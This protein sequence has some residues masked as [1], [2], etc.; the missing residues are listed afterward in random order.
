MIKISIQVL[1]WQIMGGRA[2]FFVFATCFTKS[3]KRKQILH[4]GTY[5]FSLATYQ[6]RVS[7]LSKTKAIAKRSS[8]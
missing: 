6:T 3:A 7:S 1:G 4:T 2:M 8:N 5:I